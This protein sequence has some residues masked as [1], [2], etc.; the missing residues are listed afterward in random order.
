MSSDAWETP[1]LL[2]KNIGFRFG[3]FTLDV[4]A[5]ADNAK[6]AKFFTESDDGLRQDW[7]GLVWC[8]PPYSNIMP[9]VLKA[10]SEADAGRARTVMLL[11]ARTGAAWFYT[12]LCSPLVTVH[13]FADPRIHFV[14]PPGVKPSSPTSSSLL[15]VFD[16]AYAAKWSGKVAFFLDR[17]G[18]SFFAAT[19]G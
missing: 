18:Y 15:L 12:A 7:S 10:L 4:A 19:G 6:C 2:F 14:P 5:S 17:D 9:W 11:P 8:N 3:E 1:P 16:A 13:F